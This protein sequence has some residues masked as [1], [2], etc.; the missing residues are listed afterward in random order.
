MNLGKKK[1]K[2]KHLY[3]KWGEGGQNGPLHPGQIKIA[4]FFGLLMQSQ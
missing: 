4:S 2:K 1:R 3:N